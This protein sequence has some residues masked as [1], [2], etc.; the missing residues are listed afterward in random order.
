[1]QF[2]QQRAEYAPSLLENKDK[3]VH[4]YLCFIHSINFDN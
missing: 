2:P 4:I 1:M 3:I